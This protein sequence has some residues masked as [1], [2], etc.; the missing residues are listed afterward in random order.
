MC[1]LTKTHRDYFC[2]AERSDPMPIE[3]DYSETFGDT[4]TFEISLCHSLNDG[5]EICEP[6]D[7]EY[8][9]VTNSKEHARLLS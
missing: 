8:A 2:S 7:D 6:L 3:S 5:S 1:L 9:P 4:D